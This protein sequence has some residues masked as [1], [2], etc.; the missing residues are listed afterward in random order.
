MITMRKYN[1]E[2]SIV[3][4]GTHELDFSFVLKLTANLSDFPAIIMRSFMH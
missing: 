1:V 2:I 3:D 4:L